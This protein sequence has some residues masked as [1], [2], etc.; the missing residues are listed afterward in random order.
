VRT[1]SFQ[2]LAS[3]IDRGR[4]GGRPG[5]GGAGNFPGRVA[6][7]SLQSVAWGVYNLPNLG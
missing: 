3:S 7:K 1:G 4:R 5:G 2:Y 6:A